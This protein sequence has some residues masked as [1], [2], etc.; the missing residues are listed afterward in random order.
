M[1]EQKVQ[2]ITIRSVTTRC[3]FE[4]KVFFISES[5]QIASRLEVT[6]L[7]VTDSFTVVNECVEKIASCNI[8]LLRVETFLSETFFKNWIKLISTDTQIAPS[9]ASCGFLWFRPLVPQQNKIN[10]RCL[11]K[12]AATQIRPVKLFFVVYFTD[13]RSKLECYSRQIRDCRTC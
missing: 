8:Y 3:P 7:L 13:E 9:V 12:M 2:K 1:H 5:R 4:G 6:L 11:S 10:K